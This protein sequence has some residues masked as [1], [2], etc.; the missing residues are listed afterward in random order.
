M[1]RGILNAQA[2]RFDRDNFL[3]LSALFAWHLTTERIM[4]NKIE[5]TAN[6]KALREGSRPGQRNR[7][8]S[9]VGLFGDYGRG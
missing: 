7:P 9:D 3:P 8:W 2:C 6:K 4:T 1:T 5:F